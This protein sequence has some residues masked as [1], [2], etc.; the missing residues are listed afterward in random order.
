[1]VPGMRFRTAVIGD[2]RRFRLRLGHALLISFLVH[3]L[4]LSMKFDLPGLGM[5]GSIFSKSE[6]R[7]DAS[8]MSVKIEVTPEQRA[9]ASATVPPV[10]DR[11]DA[12]PAVQSF[13]ASAMT[14]S[15]AV[16][17]L[18]IPAPTVPAPGPVPDPAPTQANRVVRRR[19]PA[20]VKTTDQAAALPPPQQIMPE[21]A[22]PSSPPVVATAVSGVCG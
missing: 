4:I 19:K 16:A 21:L 2:L 11:Q 18:A 1:M 9:P 12:A 8:A 22:V 15:L 3:A 14:A 10:P 5:P 20:R 7:V 6:R 17:A 13:Q